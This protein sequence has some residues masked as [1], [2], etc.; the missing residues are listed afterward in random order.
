MRDLVGLDVALVYYP[1]HLA[2]AVA[3]TDEVNG[4]YYMHEGRRFVVCDPTI[5]PGRVGQVMDTYANTKA[6]LMLLRR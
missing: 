3:F 6:T 1:G 5:M 4:N 2:A